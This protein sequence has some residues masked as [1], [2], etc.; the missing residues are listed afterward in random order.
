MVSFFERVR[1]Y[2]IIGSGFNRVKQ[3]E[4]IECHFE[5]NIYAVIDYSRHGSGKGQC[6]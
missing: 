4:F 5:N 3:A 2:G 1:V 6:L